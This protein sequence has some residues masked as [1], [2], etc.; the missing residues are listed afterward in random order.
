M[1]FFEVSGFR[2][3]ILKGSGRSTKRWAYGQKMLRDAPD[4]I[5][6]QHRRDYTDADAQAVCEMLNARDS[7]KQS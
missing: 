6:A 2:N 1:K 5:R 4:A 3:C 7:V